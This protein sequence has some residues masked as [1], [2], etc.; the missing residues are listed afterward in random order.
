MADREEGAVAPNQ[1]QGQNQKQNQEPSG[2]QHLHTNWSNFK[3]EFSGKPKEDAE[4]HLL[5]S[6]D[7]MNAQHFNDDVKVQRFLSYTVRRGKIVL[8]FFRTLRRYNM[9]STSQ[10]MN[11]RNVTESR[12]SFNTRDEL[13]DKIDKLTVVMSMLAA[14]DSHEKRP[15]KPKYIR[16]EVRIDLI[17]RSN[18]RNRGQFT[19]NRPRQNYRN[20]NF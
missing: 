13:G 10:F 12:V 9:A 1:R 11:V 15:F 16:V 18:S 4:A 14:K 8:P 6:N 2:Q 5:C 19:N 3:P 17:I 20:S 7:W